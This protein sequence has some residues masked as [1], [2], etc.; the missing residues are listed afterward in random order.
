MNNPPSFSVSKD[1]LILMKNRTG[2]FAYLAIASCLGIAVSRSGTHWGPLSLLIVFFLWIYLQ[3]KKPL[4]LLLLTLLFSAGF[5][6]YMNMIESQNVSVHT[7]SETR[8]SGTITTSIHID[9]NKASFEMKSNKKES[10]VVEYYLQEQQEITLLESLEIGEL[11]NWQGALKIPQ[12][13]TNPHA[14]DYKNY[15]YEQKKYWIFSLDRLPESCAPGENISIFKGLQK[16][17]DKGIKT[18]DEHMDPVVASFIISLIFG[19]RRYLDHMVLEAYQ[20]LGLIHLLA[21]SG[22]HVGIITAAAFYTG[23]RLGLTRQSVNILLIL[24]LPLYVVLAGGAPSVM[25]AAT[26]TGVALVLLLFK[27]KI[28]SI[29]TIGLA[30][31][32]VLLLNPY[33]MYHIGFQL[34]FSVSM[35]LILTSRKISTVNNGLLQIFYVSFIAQVASLPLLL[36][37]FYQF[38]IW[39]PF[40]NIIYVPFFSLFVLPGAFLLF[41]AMIFYPGLLPLLVP[42]FSFPLQLLN[43]LAVWFASIPFGTL[44]FG[45]PFIGM[46]GLLVSFTA[47]FFYLWEKER[48]SVASAMLVGCLCF[49]WYIPYTNPYGKVVVVDIGQGDAIFIRLPFNKGTYLIDTGGAFPFPKEAWK[50]RKR[51]YNSGIDVL[52]PFLR[53]EGVRKLDKLILS[54]GDYDHIGNVASLWGHVKVSEVVVP[55]GFGGSEL[56]EEILLE[57]DYRGAKIQTAVPNTGWDVDTASFLYLHPAKAYENKN[58]GSIALYAILG[59]RS[60]LFTGDMEGEGEREVL[61]RYPNITVDVLK[62][63]HHGSKTSTGQAFVE[64]LQPDIAIISAGRNN[65]FGHPHQEVLDRLERSEAMVYRTDRQGA[66]IFEFTHRGGTFSTV[67]P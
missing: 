10:M 61:L 58:E 42:F 1:N 62:A 47:L 51:E 35:A 8:I 12:P 6:G 32:F 50:E 37:H 43:S 3:D 54:H 27:K 16:Y 52:L 67:L 64:R 4:R 19:E 36:F 15:L 31:I 55:L 57:A 7:G 17:R 53:A 20:K 14:F 23:I 63:G 25:R 41:F 30:C 66:I 13:A 5:Y 39:S 56:E 26:M 34:S 22:L 59:D 65:R 21:I 60:W 28:L 46:M 2:Y 9:G 49:Q 33:Y 45:K 48:L 38:S 40:L 18:I 29:D 44:V 24:L 11:C